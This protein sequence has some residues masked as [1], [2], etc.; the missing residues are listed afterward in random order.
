M[1]DNIICFRNLDIGTERISTIGNIG[2][3][4]FLSIYNKNDKFRLSSFIGNKNK[5]GVHRNLSNSSEI[6]FNLHL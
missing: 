6:N 3:T 1:F 5:L 2:D 4:L